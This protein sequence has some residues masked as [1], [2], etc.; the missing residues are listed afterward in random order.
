MALA[1]A[2]DLRDT[3]VTF[4]CLS[5]V[6][7]NTK[8]KERITYKVYMYVY[9]R[10]YVWFVFGQINKK[11]VAR[12]QWESELERGTHARARARGRTQQ[13]IDNGRDERVS[14]G[15]LACSRISSR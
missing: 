7:L 2:R 15:T 1:I 3:H 10:A 11:G 5:V 4:Y 14:V 13:T 9:V 8:E 12:Q 6:S